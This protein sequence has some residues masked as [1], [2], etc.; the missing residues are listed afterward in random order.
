[1]S[2]YSGVSLLSGFSSSLLEAFM[3]CKLDN[4]NPEGVL[5][6]LLDKPCYKSIEIPSDQYRKMCHDSG[7]FYQEQQHSLSTKRR[8]VVNR[9]S[10]VG[11][12]LLAALCA[13]V[14]VLMVRN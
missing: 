10:S 11:M 5:V 4:I 14:S 1:M 7:W 6:Q 9:L 3:S 8:P 2:E 13:T 12:F